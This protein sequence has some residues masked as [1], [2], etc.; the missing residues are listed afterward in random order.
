[1]GRS[2]AGGV[3][4]YYR[5][6]FLLWLRI[7]D[8]VFRNQAWGWHLTT[9]LAHVL[10]TLLVYLLAWRLGIDRDVALVGGADFRPSSRPH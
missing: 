10:T 9:I 1:M 2:N 4:N 8:A 3:G 5:P 7:N 6:L